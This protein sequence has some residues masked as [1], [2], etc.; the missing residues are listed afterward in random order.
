MNKKRKRV[1][2]YRIA[3]IN[4]LGA[5]C[6]PRRVYKRIVDMP[7]RLLAAAIRERVDYVDNNARGT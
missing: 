1:Q 3:R 7:V 2:M 4:V 6:K 5:S